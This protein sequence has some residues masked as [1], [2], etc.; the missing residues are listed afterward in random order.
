MCLFAKRR[1]QERIARDIAA[2][3]NLE[4]DYRAARRQGL[5]PVEALEEWDLLDEEAKKKLKVTSK[6]ST[7]EED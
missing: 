5:S 7:Y 4:A 1:R 6:N 2:S 3:R